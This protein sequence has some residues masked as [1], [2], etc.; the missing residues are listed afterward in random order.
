MANL[1]I[2]KMKLRDIEGVLK[3]ERMSFSTPWTKDIFI[4]EV[5]RNQHAHYYVMEIND[6][7]VGY[8]GS[9]VVMDDA[10]ITNIAIMPDLR[11]NKLGEKLFR[12]TM[13]Q[14][15]TLGVKRLSLEVRA[16]NLPAQKLYK[17]FGMVP[18]GIRK[19]YYQDDNEDAIVMWVNLV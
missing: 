10:Q 12:F 4:Q 18:G 13:Q 14:L 16:S 7:I 5:E 17:K 11:G 8:V 1:K 19:N 2:R 3:V 9:W 6:S 15:V